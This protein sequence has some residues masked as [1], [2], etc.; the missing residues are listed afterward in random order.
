MNDRPAIVRLATAQQ[1]LSQAG[2]DE[3]S[4]E[5]VERDTPM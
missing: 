1:A 4:I 3:A 5:K 2:V